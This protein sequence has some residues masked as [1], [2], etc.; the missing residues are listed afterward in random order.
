MMNLVA[1]GGFLIVDSDSGTSPLIV[2]RYQ[3]DDGNKKYVLT[4]KTS[5]AD[6]IR[7]VKNQFGKPAR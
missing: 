1:I 3:Y 6:F 2:R 4:A 5:F 7:S